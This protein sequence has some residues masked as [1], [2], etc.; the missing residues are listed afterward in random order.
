VSNNKMCVF[1]VHGNEIF[2]VRGDTNRGAENEIFPVRED[3]NRGV[4]VKA[5]L[6][7]LHRYK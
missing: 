5:T 2:P 6:I 4:K 1:S 3:T 7:R